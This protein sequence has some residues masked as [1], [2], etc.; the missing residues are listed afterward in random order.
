MRTIPKALSLAK[1]EILHPQDGIALKEA[2]RQNP[3]ETDL[4]GW[5]LLS[6]RTWLGIPSRDKSAKIAWNSTPESERH[7]NSTPP[8][9]FP[10][11]WDIGA[12]GHVALSDGNGYCISTD[13]KR[14][15]K[16]DRVRIDR[17]TNQ[18]NAKY[19]G[20]TETLNGKRIPLPS[21]PPKPKP[22][23]PSQPHSPQGKYVTVKAGD[24]LTKLA[25]NDWEKSWDHANNKTI[26]H[27]RK[28]P[29]R[30]QVGDRL[31]IDK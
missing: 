3:S 8:K 25:G 9:G 19:L 20:W 15:G 11:F 13:I 31:W 7:R 21:K 28:A 26:R 22:S 27:L 5:C 4:L 23:P 6:V 24:T 10:V 16:A 14:R 2:K 17:V 29:D 1:Y 18:W 30:I 12:H